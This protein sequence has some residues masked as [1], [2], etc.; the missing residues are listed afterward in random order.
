MEQI[1]A[2]QKARELQIDKTQV[3]REYWELIILKGLF[4]SSE[5]Q[6]LIFK[7][8]TALRLVYGSPRFSQDLDFSLIKNSNFPEF[9][10]VIKK[11]EKSRD[12]LAIKDIYDKRNTLFAL[13]LVK[14]KLLN[15]SFFI[16][17]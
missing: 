9:V 2:E 3:V 5:G 1:I 7:G 4:D 15:Q 16:T 13:L 8:G 6:A 10:R 11:I 14:N 17:V 12:G